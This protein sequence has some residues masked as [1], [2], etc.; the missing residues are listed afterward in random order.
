MGMFDTVL[1]PQT[2]YKQVVGAV[3]YIEN[4]TDTGKVLYGAGV[5]ISKEG[6]ILTAAHV[7]ANSN[8]ISIEFSDG[9][10]V[11]AHRSSPFDEGRDLAT[12]KIDNPT[13]FFPTVF[14]RDLSINPL[15]IGAK[16][17]AIGH[18]LKQKFSYSEGIVSQLRKDILNPGKFVIHEAIQ[19]DAALNPGNSGGGAFDLKGRLI[20][21]A[22]IILSPSGYYDGIGY[23]TGTTEIV[24]FLGNN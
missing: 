7:L 22:N 2:L 5:V 24:K 4:L 16:L 19:T 21:I 17:F 18:P 10:K 9:S 11:T 14:M 12:C 13:K 1:S 8:L 15:N 6:S 23:L 20:G 3:V